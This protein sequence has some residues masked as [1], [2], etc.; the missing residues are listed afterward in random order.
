[1]ATELGVNKLSASADV[2]VNLVDV[3]D[4]KPQFLKPTYE[5]DI[6]E[7][8]PPGVQIGRVSHNKSYRVDNAF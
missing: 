7:N 5:I 2:S 4:N 6:V 3:N 1:L 8:Q